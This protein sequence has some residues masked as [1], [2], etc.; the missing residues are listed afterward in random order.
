MTSQLV[1]VTELRDELDTDS[2]QLE[3]VRRMIHA[4][5]T[6]THVQPKPT[7]CETAGIPSGIPA[8]VAKEKNGAGG[9]RTPVPIRPVHRVNERFRSFNLA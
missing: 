6:Q 2:P 9:I 7:F 5:F 1:W 8:P 4:R 3:R